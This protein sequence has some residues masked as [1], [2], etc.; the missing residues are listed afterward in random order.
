MK[1]RKVQVVAVVVL[2]TVFLAS[3]LMVSC[4]STRKA[5]CPAYRRVSVQ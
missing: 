2:L 3:M 4:S 5:P 1:M